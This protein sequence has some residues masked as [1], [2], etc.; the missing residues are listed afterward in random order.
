MIFTYPLG[1]FAY[2]MMPFGLCNAPSTFKICMMAIFTDYIDNFMEM[3]MDD[4]S[5]FGSSFDVCFANLSTVLKRCEEVNLVLSWEKVTSWSK[6]ELCWVTKYLKKGLRLI[7]S[8]VDLISNLPVPS[9]VKQVRSFPSHAGFY[10]RFIKD[11]SKVA[12]PLINLLTKDAPFVIDESCVKA[13]EKLRSLLVSAPIVQP[14]NF[15]CRLRLCVM[16]LI[17]LL[18][19]FWVKG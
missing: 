10:R 2:R 11:F 19:L 5:V 13:F 18:R 15:I 14:P 4:F 17:L 8:T 7:K 6:K 12:R 16:H 3:F 9:S 1:I